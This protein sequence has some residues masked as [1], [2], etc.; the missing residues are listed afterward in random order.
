MFC[1]HTRPGLHSVAELP[2]V[3]R[4]LPLQAAGS[5]Q[6]K[7]TPWILSHRG[8]RD[9]SRR[10]QADT[11]VQPILTWVLELAVLR[12]RAFSCAGHHRGAR[13]AE[14]GDREEETEKGR[15]LSINLSGIMLL[16]GKHS[17]TNEMG[18][19]DRVRAVHCAVQGHRPNSGDWS[20]QTHSPVIWRTHGSNHT[21]TCAAGQK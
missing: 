14:D 18:S 3:P 16:L 19:A 2:Q 10:G 1:Q 20:S 21:A 11:Y 8:G 17:G 5:G 15:E 4:A 12:V 7:S 6:G 13:L 9:F